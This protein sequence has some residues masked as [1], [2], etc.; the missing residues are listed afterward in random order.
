MNRSYLK[1]TAVRKRL[2]WMKEASRLGVNQ[3]CLKLGIHK[4]QYYY[5]YR[6]FKVS[7][8]CGLLALSRRPHSS[9][10]L[11]KGLL[12]HR[13]L[14]LRKETRRGPDTIALLL[15]TRFGMKIPRSTVYKILKRER[16]IDK[17]QR[18]FKKK[19]PLRYACN[20][21]GQRVQIDV[22]YVPYRLKEGTY[23]R[24]YQ[25]TAIDDCTR[26][27]FA[28]IYDGHGILQLEDFLEKLLLF[29][30]FKIK[31]IQT[32]NHVIFTYKLSAHKR[33]F[34]KQLKEHFLESFCKKHK[35]KHHL[36]APGEPELNGKVERSHQSDQKYF[37]D[38]HHFKELKPLQDKFHHWIDYYNHHRPHWG[39]KGL[40]PVQ[41]LKSYAYNLE[42][43]NKHEKHKLYSLKHA[44]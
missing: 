3:A 31:L 19:H 41:K 23:G 4:S 1:D 13:V 34:R 26:V 12:V 15:H 38:Y 27:R 18:R 35:I 16:K 21:P 8:V 5:W 2:F 24:A 44:A 32:D 33:T 40:T 10:K 28:Y 30:P 36:I 14:R 20:K 7:G 25:Y 9:P 22:K 17:K 29:F 42:R 39:L 6:R 43:I 37:Y 11:S